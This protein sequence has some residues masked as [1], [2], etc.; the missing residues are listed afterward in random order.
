MSADTGPGRAPAT[1]ALVAA[2][3]RYGAT[4]GIARAIG[5]ELARHGILVVVLAPEDVGSIESYQAVILGSAVYGGRW[6]EPAKELV[7]RCAAALAVR[8]VW[9]FSSGPI[10]DP[11]RK[12]VR[13]MRQDPADL[14]GLLRTT[15]ARGHRMFAGKLD[16]RNLS[17]AQ[18][19]PLL[20]LRKLEGDFRDWAAIRAWAADIAGQLASEAADRPVTGGESAR[21]RS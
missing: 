20:L 10:G 3:S 21:R 14:P 6:L 7:T 11:A 15:G 19:M 13:S 9:L 12:L 1:R 8:P 2:S 17:F 18:R 5:E 16:R 4:T